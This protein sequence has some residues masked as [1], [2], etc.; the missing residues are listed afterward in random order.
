MEGAEIDAEIDDEILEMVPLTQ[1][2]SFERSRGDGEGLG[3]R[4]VGIEASRANGHTA[5]AETRGGEEPRDDVDADVA[6]D[7]QEEGHRLLSS[8]GGHGEQ[9]GAQNGAG[10]TRDPESFHGHVG[11]LRGSGEV[12]GF[13]VDGSGGE[14]RRLCA[15]RYWGGRGS[16][17]WQ[18][19]LV[20]ARLLQDRK[21]RAIILVYAVFSVRC[22]AVPRFLAAQIYF[23]VV[24]V[25][26]EGGWLRFRQSFRTS[27]F[28]ANAA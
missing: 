22:C 16:A 8:H 3:L 25:D 15:R 7:S 14:S 21:T 5:D 9:F 18:E 26:S 10:Q 23:Y 12:G 17:C 11:G 24:F 4:A 27:N 6:E 19:F 1:T 2:K 20:P 13:D 28:P